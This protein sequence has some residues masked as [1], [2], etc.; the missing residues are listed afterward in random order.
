M[1]KFSVVMSLFVAAALLVTSAYAGKP[2]GGTAATNL[3]VGRPA[4]GM[5]CADP[6]GWIRSGYSGANGIYVWNNGTPVKAQDLNADGLLILPSTG[7]TYNIPSTGQSGTMTIGD[8]A[9]KVYI[10]TPNTIAADKIFTGDTAINY[11]AEGKTFSGVVRRWNSSCDGCHAL[12]P[13]HAIANKATTPGTSLCR[14]CHILGMK[15]H[16]SHALRVPAGEKTTS[17]AC[18]R[19]HPSPC[20]SG[21]HTGKFPGDSI[22][23]ISC[24]GSLVD[25]EAGNMKIP[26]Q[27]GF[28]K[29]EGCH[30]SVPNQPVPYANN[31]G[32]EYKDSV[33]HGRPRAA[34]ALCITC[35]NSMHMET[36]PMSWG[37]GVNNNCQVCHKNMPTANNMGPNCANCHVNSFN[38]HLVIK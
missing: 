10:A 21:I 37:D 3:I 1:K 13:A 22:G 32:N 18:Y 27:L 14:N 28:P 29:C 7:I 8:A 26:G 2:G 23:C 24:H 11:T 15:L 36:K 38:P 35:H 12:P 31:A 34:K 16:T 19:C 33:G 25:A 17:D 4:K 6:A 30:T 9:N 5:Y 20:Y